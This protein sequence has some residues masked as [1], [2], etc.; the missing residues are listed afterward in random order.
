M[1]P[2]ISPEDFPALPIPIF[3]ALVLVGF[4]AGIAWCVWRGKSQNIRALEVIEMTLWT[5]IPAYLGGHIIDA[6][7]YF[8]EKVMA[9]PMYLLDFG[10]GFVY[11]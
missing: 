6:L 11:C 5:A 1:I 7:V 2:Y 9:D 8:P 4:L 10:K 3:S